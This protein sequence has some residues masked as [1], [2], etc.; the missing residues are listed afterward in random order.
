M[1]KVCPA[2]PIRN[3]LFYFKLF[4]T[5]NRTLIEVIEDQESESEVGFSIRAFHWLESR[6]IKNELFYFKVFQTFN[7]SLV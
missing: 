5:F 3:E 1:L 4:R 7:R 2:K 6:P